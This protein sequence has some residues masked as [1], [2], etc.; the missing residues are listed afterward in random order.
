MI[1]AEDLMIGNY[2]N[3]PVMGICQV[4]E[5]GR[6]YYNCTSDWKDWF[7]SSD[8]QPIPL[9]PDVLERLGFEKQD[10]SFYFIDDII[11]DNIISFGINGQFGLVPTY[12]MGDNTIQQIN[13]LHQLQNLYK[14]LTG[15]NLKFKTT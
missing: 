8:S 6:G 10:K 11:S 2:V 1:A 15:K 7:S 14:A 12:V 9:T 3:H 5:I 4:Y 13:Y